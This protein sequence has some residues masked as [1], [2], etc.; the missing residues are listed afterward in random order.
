MKKYDWQ[1]TWYRIKCKIF[2]HNFSCCNEIY[3]RCS[4]CYEPGRIQPNQRYK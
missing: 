1:Y 4:K 2:G 3:Q